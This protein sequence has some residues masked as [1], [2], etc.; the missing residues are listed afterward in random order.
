M[1]SVME[2]IQSFLKNKTL[3]DRQ[4]EVEFTLERVDPK[5]N[6]RYFR[7]FEVS[8][9]ILLDR[10]SLKSL[11]SLDYNVGLRASCLARSQRCNS[12]Q[13]NG[14][15]KTCQLDENNDVQIIHSRDQNAIKWGFLIT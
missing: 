6:K 13:E 14:R 5:T 15:A 9:K 10:F 11:N 7:F 4:E 3:E 2:D 12:R 8:C 1:V